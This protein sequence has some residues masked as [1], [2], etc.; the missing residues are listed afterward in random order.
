MAISAKGKSLQLRHAADRA[1]GILGESSKKALVYH[2]K[3]RYGIDIFDDYDHHNITI[4]ELEYALKDLMGKE[5]GLLLMGYVNTELQ[6]LDFPPPP[7]RKEKAFP[8]SFH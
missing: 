4:A 1:F 8:Y 5:A 2:L 7:I 6:K 3:E